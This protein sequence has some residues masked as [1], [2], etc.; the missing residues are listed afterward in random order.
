MHI[1]STMI[2]SPILNRIWTPLS[3]NRGGISLHIFFSYMASLS[4]PYCPALRYPDEIT[5]LCFRNC[6]ISLTVFPT[7][8]L[9]VTFFKLSLFLNV[10]SQPYVVI[11]TYKWVQLIKLVQIYLDPSNITLFSIEWV[12]AACNRSLAFPLHNPAWGVWLAA[13]SPFTLHWHTF[14]PA[15]PGL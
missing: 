7:K 13:S 2:L 5:A 12:S 8:A 15:S 10:S 11:R 9:I 14:H 4:I 3:K 6:W 1:K